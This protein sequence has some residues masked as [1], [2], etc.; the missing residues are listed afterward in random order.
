MPAP[1]CPTLARPRI[2]VVAVQSVVGTFYGL[3]RDELL[4][5]CTQRSVS[6][7][8]QVAMYLAKH[9][10]RQSYPNLGRRFGNRD[11]TTVLHAVRRVA[12]WREND[13]SFDTLIDGLTLE[14]TRAAGA[15][16]SAGVAQP[17]C[18]ISTSR[19]WLN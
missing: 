7:P 8:R 18:C 19:P 14:L 17:S 5:R 4:S 12:S 15:V 2:T 6:A 16:Q 9:L 10:T 13:A 3:T 11:H 1:T